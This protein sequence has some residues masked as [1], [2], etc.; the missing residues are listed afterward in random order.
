ME[1][2]KANKKRKKGNIEEPEYEQSCTQKRRR[3]RP[4]GSIS[5]GLHVCLVC[6]DK[7]K[8]SESRS[9]FACG[10]CRKKNEIYGTNIRAEQLDINCKPICSLC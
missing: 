9:A 1:D 6:E 2:I 5:S 7:E 10:K 8:T 4:A 3:G